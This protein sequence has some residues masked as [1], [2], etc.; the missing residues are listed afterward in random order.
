MKGLGTSFRLANTQEFATAW[1]NGLR[2]ALSE[3][4][5][6]LYLLDAKP[7]LYDAVNRRPV[8]LAAAKKAG[9]DFTIRCV[10]KGLKAKPPAASKPSGREP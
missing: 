6:Q 3:A 1:E 10:A 2:F 7:P 4:D 8:E 9:T 5:N